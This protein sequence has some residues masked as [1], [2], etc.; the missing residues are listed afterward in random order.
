[1]PPQSIYITRSTEEYAKSYNQTVNSVIREQKYLVSIKEFSL[2]D[3]TNHLK[4]ICD[5]NFPQY[6]LLENNIVIGWC[7]IIPRSITGYKHVGLLGMGLLSKFRGKGYGKILAE[8]T[9]EHATHI[10]KLEK[11]ELVVFESNIIAYKLYKKLGFFEE[12]KRLK[13]RKINGQYDNEILMGK[14]L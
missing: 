6:F 10:T 4:L 8:K 2:E 3:T 1:M 13:T 11:V 9:I 12:G 7:D 5:N 14:F